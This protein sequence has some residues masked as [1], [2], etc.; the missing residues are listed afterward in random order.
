MISV[1]RVYEIVRDLCNKDQKGFVTPNVFDTMAR[2]AQQNIYNEMFTELK[3]ATALRASG[4]DAGR[5]K[6]AYKMVEEDLSTYIRHVLVDDNVDG[7]ETVGNYLDDNG[8]VVGDFVDGPFTDTNAMVSSY[9]TDEG[10]GP[11]SFRR[12]ADFGRSISMCVLAT[13][14]SIEIIYDNEKA[15]RVLNSN[16]SSPTD[17]FPV[18]LEMTGVYQVFPSTVDGVSMRYYRQPRS[19]YTDTGLLD[20]SSHPVFATLPIGN[21]TGAVIP[22]AF[23]SRNF[24]LPEHYIGEVVSEIVKMIG[25]RLRD[26]ALATYGIQQTQAE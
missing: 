20:S 6:S 13:N 17:E 11:F 21:D 4:R 9:G 12:P 15:S 19:R 10:D 23:D 16:L 26:N 24:D 5:D 8:V 7:F 22:N 2:V 3:L 25:I 18:A 1:H 14:T